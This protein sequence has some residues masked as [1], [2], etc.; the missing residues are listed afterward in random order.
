VSLLGSVEERFTRYVESLEQE[1]ENRPAFRDFRHKVM[2]YLERHSESL[3]AYTPEQLISEANSFEELLA[4]QEFLK[5]KYGNEQAWWD[6]YH[7]RRRQLATKPSYYGAEK[8]GVPVGPEVYHRGWGKGQQS[9]VIHRN[10]F[11]KQLSYSQVIGQ[12]PLWGVDKSGG[13]PKSFSEPLPFEPKHASRYISFDIETTG[14]LSQLKSPKTGSERGLYSVGWSTE[15]GEGGWLQKALLPRAEGRWTGQRGRR[16]FFGHEVEEILSRGEKAAAR[17]PEQVRRVFSEK[18]LLSDFLRQ[19]ERQPRERALLGYNIQGFDIP[20][21]KAMAY[22]HGMTKRFESA[23]SGRQIID[24]AEEAKGFLSQQ[25]SG[26][27]LGWQRSMFE[28]MGMSAAGWKLESI[29]H[30][31]GYEHKVGELAHTPKTDA[32]MAAFVHEVL[33]DKDR[34]QRIWTRGGEQ[35]YLQDLSA[36]GVKLK[37]LS[38]LEDITETR[39]GQVYLKPQ[40]VL[41]P[42]DYDVSLLSRLSEKYGARKPPVA[43]K[44]IASRIPEGVKT[45]GRWGTKGLKYAAG[46]AALGAVLPGQGPS[47]LVGAAAAVGTWQLMKRAGGGLPSKLAAAAMSY[48]AVK[49]TANAF[50]SMS[51]GGISEEIRHLQT[52]FGSPWQGPKVSGPLSIGLMAGAAAVVG[53]G[54][55]A[56]GL[57]SETEEPPARERVHGQYIDPRIMEF[58]RKWIKDPGKRRELERLK[59]KAYKPLQPGDLEDWRIQGK[60]QKIARV[61]LSGLTPVWEDVD[62]LLLKHAWYQPWKKDIGIRL[63]GIDAPEILHEDD[64]LPWT[65]RKQSQPYGEE[66]VERLKELVGDEKLELYIAGG[67]DQRTYK[68]YLGAVYREGSDIPI[69]VEAVQQGLAAALPWGE[70]GTD[71]IPRD[72]LIEE[73]RRASQARR[74]MWQ[75]EYWQRYLD[76]S[77][78]AGR[79][80]TFTS[81]SDLS[82]LASNLHLAAAEELMSRKDIDYEPWMAQ[83]IGE[84]LQVNYA[85]SSSKTKN[86]IDGLHYGSEGLGAELMRLHSDFGSGAI[87]GALKR[88]GRWFRQTFLSGRGAMKK[89]GS[90]KREMRQDPVFGEEMKYLFEQRRGW[91]T[92]AGG[93]TP[94]GVD[95]KAKG[96]KRWIEENPSIGKQLG[97][98][99]QLS[100]EIG[101]L[102]TIFSREAMGADTGIW[103]P[104]GRKTV[105]LKNSEWVFPEVPEPAVGEFDPYTKE[106]LARHLHREPLLNQG[107]DV[108]N[109]AV[110]RGFSLEERQ[111]AFLRAAE[112]K[113]L[114]F[115][116][117]PDLSEGSAAAK[118][119]EALTEFKGEF[120]S[121]WDKFKHIA[122]Q[123]IKEGKTTEDVLSKG[124]RLKSLGRG[125]Y[126]EA[127]LHAVVYKGQEFKYVVKEARP[128]K[129]LEDLSSANRFLKFNK[130]VLEEEYHALANIKGDIM[131][132]AYHYDPADA[133]KL[134]MEYMPGKSLEE[135]QKAGEEIPLESIFRQINRQAEQIAE[136]KYKNLDIHEG[137]IMFDPQQGR[138]AW[139]DFRKAKYT[140]D[141]KKAEREMKKAAFA[142]KELMD[143][144]EDLPLG[145]SL[146]GPSSKKKP[147]TFPVKEKKPQALLK[148][149]SQGRAAAKLRAQEKK[150]PSVKVPHV[151]AHKAGRRHQWTNKK[152]SL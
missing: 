81:F 16:P 62:T 68:R 133:G 130:E 66:S 140:E 7:V 102:D 54:L 105:R 119:R 22:R 135:M 9:A 25:L 108:G 94:E 74:G 21:L 67:P 63:T 8:Y 44:A 37:P 39:G 132:S 46:T 136:R 87:K 106:R 28:D 57:S 10:L 122:S 150:H 124:T 127:F 142:R 110:T 2:E 34:A 152:G 42:Q 20:Y 145:V 131:P 30:A 59:D 69:N 71:I 116:A 4:L 93:L 79:R 29:A 76:L 56:M 3:A 90:L 88:T 151:S 147:R 50:D 12:E 53:G 123:L 120:A 65:R 101:C 149:S 27:Y 148:G 32:S 121:R 52:D 13:V 82:R 143:P 95:V 107:K 49:G 72:I 92:S 89:A 99:E 91:R 31:L 126:G 112:K 38:A 111:E 85:G 139:I 97:G 36:Q 1:L 138:V 6:Y 141:V 5:K 77:R 98:G 45:A 41:R 58:R 24:V 18:E 40:Q 86:K 80:V 113:G 104:P 48:A 114:K 23:V 43:P 117:M 60:G 125:E 47:N 55:A 15:A 35:R 26:K 73:E 100:R 11:P 146:W 64:P 19:L 51:K 14:L 84:K 83:Y 129:N 144:E 137:N 61:D 33:G 96:Y 75:E 134:Y 17:S 78:G 109:L 128:P 103:K 70:S 115:S 118:I